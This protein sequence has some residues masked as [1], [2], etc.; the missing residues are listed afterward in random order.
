MVLVCDLLS[1]DFVLV[2]LIQI[3][4]LISHQRDP[5]WQPSTFIQISRRQM[6]RLQI[7]RRGSV[8]FQVRL[9]ILVL[10]TTRVILHTNRTTLWCVANERGL[11][12]G[13]RM[14]KAALN[15]QTVTLARDFEHA[16]DGITVIALNPGYIATKMTGF[17]GVVD[18]VESVEK[19]TTIIEE[20]TVEKSGHFF[21]YTGEEL[22]F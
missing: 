18:L 15:Q 19:M 21:D 20:T 22:P 2:A 3:E 5:F 9:L 14:A 16:G 1:F 8:Q 6:G 7:F 17:K 4:G 13:Y 12:I 11:F 10:Y